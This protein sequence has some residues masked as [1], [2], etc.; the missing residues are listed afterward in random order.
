MRPFRATYTPLKQGVEAMVEA[1]R[2]WVPDASKSRLVLVL[3]VFAYPDADMIST[4]I[5]I[6]SD[7]TL[8]EDRISRFTDCQSDEWKEG[9][10]D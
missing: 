7:K 3:Q 2:G 4:A 9:N 8:Q 6:D 1:R 5:F 10:N